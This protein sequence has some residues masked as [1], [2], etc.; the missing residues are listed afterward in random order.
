MFDARK[1]GRG[2]STLRKNADMTQSSLADKLNLTRQAI[3][4]YELGESFPDVSVLVLIADIFNITLDELIGFGEPTKGESNILAGISRGN[5]DVVA[6]DFKDIVNLAPILKPSV[7]SKLASDFSKQGI[8]ISDVVSLAEYL[9]D[10][11]LTG[12]IE[13]AEFDSINAEL[14]ARFMPLLD[15]KSKEAI[16]KRILEGG[17]DWHIIPVMLPYADYMINQIE[18]AVVEGALPEEVLRF[19]REYSAEIYFYNTE[20]N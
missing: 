12:L 18:A 9:N 20:E 7:L 19:V 2:L 8:D 15:G 6:D 5:D 14:L 11:N 16:F 4:R 1:F 3:S 10:E 17:A 13:N